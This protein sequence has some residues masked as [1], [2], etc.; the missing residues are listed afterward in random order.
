MDLKVTNDKLE[1]LCIRGCLFDKLFLVA[2]IS[3]SSD[4]T[5]ESLTIGF[6]F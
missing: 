2:W 1:C 3:A 6:V 4:I 5:M